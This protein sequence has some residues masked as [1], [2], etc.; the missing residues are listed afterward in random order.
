MFDARRQKASFRTGVSLDGELALSPD[1]RTLVASSHE[2]V[3]HAWDLVSHRDLYAMPDA[4][5]GLVKSVLVAPDGKTA[6]TGG[7]D[8]AIRLWDLTT[9]RVSRVL[10]LSGSVNAWAL[11]P[12]GQWLAAATLTFQQIFVWDLQG[13]GGP[14]VLAT[15]RQLRDRVSAEAL[16]FADENR[17][18]LIDKAGNLHEIDVKEKKVRSGVMRIELPPADRDRNLPDLGDIRIG[19]A[20]F[21]PDGKR[22]VIHPLFAG[23]EIVD[24]ATGKR[25]LEASSGSF[26]AAS[27]DG[28]LLA[29]DAPEGQDDDRIARSPRLARRQTGFQMESSS[30]SI[31]LVETET[32]QERRSLRVE[33]GKV[34]A[35]AFA[36]DGKTMAA[37]SGRESGRIH[38]FDV[39][40]GKETRTIEA[41]PFGPSALA[42]TPDGS[43]LI[44]GMA[45]GSVLV[46]DLKAGR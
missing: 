23:M 30:G 29:G 22:I 39:S 34:S 28:R 41:P 13:Q 4:P 7:D 25:L 20:V 44:S 21:L 32:G 16:R 31:R 46:W 6:I 1:G 3:L 24:L 17:I 8:Q 11:S 18:L 14:V 45:D 35:V 2:H 33:N 27:P 40:T 10:R 38:L 19:R 37:T 42:Y 9:G 15:G 5:D 12:S 36:P 43:R 26:L